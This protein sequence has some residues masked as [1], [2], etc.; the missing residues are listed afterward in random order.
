MAANPKQCLVTAAVSITCH[1]L[2]YNYIEG[3][4]CQQTFFILFLLRLAARCLSTFPF[5]FLF[6]CSRTKRKC[7]RMPS[8]K[9]ISI[10][11]KWIE[12]KTSNYA[13][14]GDKVEGMEKRVT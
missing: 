2:K 3:M 12:L 5:A 7:V 13:S 10:P 11:D 6:S 14:S 1:V 8:A 9:I 4:T